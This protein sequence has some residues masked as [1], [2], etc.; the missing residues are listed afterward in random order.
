M[1][2]RFS[3]ASRYV[4][5]VGGA[6]TVMAILTL[7][8]PERK[9]GVLSRLDTEWGEFLIIRDETVNSPEPFVE[10]LWLREYGGRRYEWCLDPMSY[11]IFSQADLQVLSN[12]TI[13]VRL[14]PCTWT[15]HNTTNGRVGNGVSPIKVT[16]ARASGVFSHGSTFEDSCVGRMVPCG[17]SW[18]R[19]PG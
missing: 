3:K 1:R 2:R 4:F 14:F 7:W 13:Q 9:S 8:L 17:E 16:I 15:L 12:Q 10:T 18:Q 5:F 19:W 11:G 6:L